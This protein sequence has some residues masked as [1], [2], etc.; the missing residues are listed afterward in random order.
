[1]AQNLNRYSLLPYFPMGAIKE[2]P[3]VLARHGVQVWEGT[4]KIVRLRQVRSPRAFHQKDGASLRAA[5]PV[6]RGGGH[7]R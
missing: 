3:E 1:M 4:P 2:G 5:A 6:V 7:G